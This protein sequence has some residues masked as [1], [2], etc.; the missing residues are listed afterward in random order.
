MEIE[1][2]ALHM[3]IVLKNRALLMRPS[4]LEAGAMNKRL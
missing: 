2:Y 3:S 4:C 1:K